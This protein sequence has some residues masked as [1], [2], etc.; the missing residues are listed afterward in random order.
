M[1]LTELKY[2]GSGSFQKSA[3]TPFTKNTYLKVMYS[4]VLVSDI[5]LQILFCYRLLQSI[6]YSSLLYLAIQ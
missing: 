4:I 6:E 2:L 1:W 5:Q 3:S